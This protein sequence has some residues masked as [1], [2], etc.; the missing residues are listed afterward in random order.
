MWSGRCKGGWLRILEVLLAIPIVAFFILAAANLS[1]FTSPREYSS[2]HLRNLALSTLSKMDERGV[3]TNLV[4]SG[5]YFNLKA[6]LETVLPPNI[7]YNLTVYHLTSLNV[8]QG[9]EKILEKKLVREVSVSN[10]KGEG[11]P[12]TESVNYYVSPSEVSYYVQAEKSNSSI[13]LVACS[14][15][16]GWWITGYV[17]QTMAKSL[18]E[19]LVNYYVNVTIINDTSQLYSYLFEDPPVNA[20]VINC[21]GE[22]VPIPDQYVSGGNPNWIQYIRDIRGNTLNYNWTWVSIVGYP[23]YYVSNR[24]YENWKAWGVTGL[25]RVATDGLSVFATNEKGSGW[26]TRDIGIV[27][28][29]TVALEAMNTYG[30]QFSPYQSSSRALERQWMVSNGWDVELLLFDD[31]GTGY[32]PVAVFRNGGGR[33]IH[34]GLVRTPE[35]RVPVISLLA[36][37]Q[38]TLHEI[39]MN[40]EQAMKI[41]VLEVSYIG[42][43]G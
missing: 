9:K 42:G 23:F 24:N 28:M 10:F 2:L 16:P 41:I 5:D 8:S 29:T 4:W 15:A 11:S 13:Y 14:D 25:Y 21:H 39:L 19:Y 27:Y 38:P 34:T 32:L 40:L 33:F 17:P 6:E 30:I 12:W 1:P 7:A 31:K 43:G 20:T 37:T 26:R 22:A 36:L 3:L 35:I 18:K